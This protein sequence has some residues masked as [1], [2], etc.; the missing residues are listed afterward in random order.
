MTYRFALRRCVSSKLGNSRNTSVNLSHFSSS[1]SGG[2]H[3][4]ICAGVSIVPQTCSQTFPGQFW[5][6]ARRCLDPQY[7]S[8]PCLS[9]A[10]IVLFGK[11]LNNGKKLFI[12][13]QKSTFGQIIFSFKIHHTFYL[14]NSEAYIAYVNLK[15]KIIRNSMCSIILLM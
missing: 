6:W 9:C 1:K 12:S 15:N 10:K 3:D 7:L 14:I 8:R 11:F 5:T 13:N 4:V 2:E